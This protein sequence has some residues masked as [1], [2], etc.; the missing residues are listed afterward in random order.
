MGLQNEPT[1]HS[2]KGVNVLRGFN[3]VP[4]LVTETE[5]FT[6]PSRT[7]KLKRPVES[8]REKS[9][10]ENPQHTYIEQRIRASWVQYINCL[11]A[12]I[13]LKSVG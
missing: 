7:E 1:P 9:F 2:L 11:N 13:P 4:H 10:A 8:T 3:T 6:R 12:T 5:R